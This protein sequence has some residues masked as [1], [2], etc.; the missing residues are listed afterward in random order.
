MTSR[1]PWREAGDAWVNGLPEGILGSEKNHLGGEEGRTHDRRSMHS[2]ML[3][4]INEG[5][6]ETYLLISKSSV[7]VFYLSLKM[8]RHLPKRTPVGCPLNMGVP[9][10]GHTTV[11]ILSTL[12]YGNVLPFIYYFNAVIDH[13]C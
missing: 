4:S 1:L 12:T 3:C 10:F 7:C 2:V 6:K 13:G 8:L 9:D 5:A 11:C